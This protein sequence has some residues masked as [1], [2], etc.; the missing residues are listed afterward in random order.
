MIP[1]AAESILNL[2]TLKTLKDLDKLAPGFFAD[3]VHTFSADSIRMI[4]AM[5][6]AVYEQNM[7]VFCKE[8][9][10]FKG[11]A[12]NLGAQALFTLCARLESLARANNI[13]EITALLDPLRQLN[14]QTIAAFDAANAA[15]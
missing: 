6:Q 5:M 10:G 7:E 4:D 1:Q 13:S 14:A 3:L 12:G 15:A 9:H 8:A 2:N 11:M